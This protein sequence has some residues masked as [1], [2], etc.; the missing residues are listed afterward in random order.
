VRLLTEERG[1][2]LEDLI[3][4]HGR[5]F[6]AL[7]GRSDYWLSRTLRSVIDFSGEDPD[8]RGEVLIVLGTAA[9]GLLLADPEHQL[10]QMRP[11]V[12][13]HVKAGPLRP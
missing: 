6:H 5:H 10:A 9:L 7:T 2:T 3:E 1:A 13:K 12:E 11:V 8:V 4:A